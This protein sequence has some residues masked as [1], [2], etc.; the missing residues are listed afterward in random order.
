MKKLF[1]IFQKIIKD[2][3]LYPNSFDSLK[4][5]IYNLGNF[6]FKY[7]NQEDS[8]G[9]L[10]SPLWKDRKSKRIITQEQRFFDTL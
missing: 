4:D 3:F 1:I 2:E 7:I 9:F 6:L 10:I 5:F 8:A